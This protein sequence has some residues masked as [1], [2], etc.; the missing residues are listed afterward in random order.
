[1]VDPL[2]QPYGPA[3]TAAHERDPDTPVLVTG[4]AGFLGSHL[5]D[6]LLALGHQVRGLDRRHPD[7]DAGA[8]ANLA[9][10]R[11]HPRF[12]FLHAD[13]GHHDVGPA[14]TGC[15]TVYHLADPDTVTD[16]QAVRD[17]T[18]SSHVSVT[19]NLLQ[20]CHEA[21]T[22]RLVYAS[23][24]DIYGPTVGPVRETD[25][26]R[27]ATIAALATAIAEQLCLYGHDPHNPTSV[28]ALR[29]ADIYG[30]RQRP[31]QPVARI[32]AAAHTGAPLELYGTPAGPRR[33]VYV[34]D[35]VRAALA[36]ATVPATS[37][38]VN[39]ASPDTTTLAQL[40]DTM[41]TVAGVELPTAGQC[42]PHEA[43]PAVVDGSAAYLLLGYQPHIGVAEGLRR[44]AHWWAHHATPHRSLPPAST[45]RIGCPSP[46]QPESRPR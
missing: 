39:I 10:A 38:V 37:A 13:L 5:V 33:Y 12:T 3:L 23:S 29:Y 19:A 22:R 24:C 34:T 4:A 26:A 15:D 27:P 41:R 25:P 20:A 32:V 35:A 45:P 36:A 7:H 46:A 1:M 8:A 28:V 6:A 18:L 30:P 9:G 11:Q 2:T 44:Y 40:I 43:A 14:V 16:E 21:G 42:P 31:H 17:A